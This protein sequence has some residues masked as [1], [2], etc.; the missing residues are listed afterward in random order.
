LDL[1]NGILLWKPG[2]KVNK[3]IVE[4]ILF[5][6]AQYKPYLVKGAG[7]ADSKCKLGFETARPLMAR[8]GNG[9]FIKVDRGTGVNATQEGAG[10]QDVTTKGL[11]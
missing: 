1:N 8:Y 7:I 9:L 6:V 10:K 5:I 4:I 2:V 3:Y 11:K